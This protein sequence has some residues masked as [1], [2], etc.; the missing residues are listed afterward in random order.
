[1]KRGSGEIQGRHP[2]RSS[3]IRPPQTRAVVRRP[4]IT[5]TAL[6]ARSSKVWGLGMS[7]PLIGGTSKGGSHRCPVRRCQHGSVF[8]RA[9]RRPQRIRQLRSES[10]KQKV[11]SSRDGKM[12]ES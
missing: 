1:M 7:L 9:R 12:H 8:G 4:I 3:P 10:R 5:Q 11:E 2:V 6:L